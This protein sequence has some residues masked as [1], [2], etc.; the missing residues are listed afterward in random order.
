VRSSQGTVLEDETTAA[1]PS[2]CCLLCVGKKK[3]EQEKK[4]GHKTQK[5]DESAR[6]NND[7]LGVQQ[8]S[9]PISVMPGVPGE[10]KA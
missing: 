8:C 10:C 6:K 1:L 3:R 9:T 5:I 7:R 2:V 4:S